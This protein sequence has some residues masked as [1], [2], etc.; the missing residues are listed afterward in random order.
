MPVQCHRV[1]LV[2]D[3][4]RHYHVNI[5]KTR[6]MPKRRLNNFEKV[7]WKS[8]TRVLVRLLSSYSQFS[9]DIDGLFSTKIRG[10]NFIILLI[11]A[12]VIF[13][14]VFFVF[15]SSLSDYYY[16]YSWWVPIKTKP[17][18]ELSSAYLAKSKLVYS[19]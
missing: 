8:K 6:L 17:S 19:K 4:K 10:S 7:H 18:Q 11:V 2:L 14:I 12:L 16:Y 5:L 9:T 15:S 1:N 3:K 13:I